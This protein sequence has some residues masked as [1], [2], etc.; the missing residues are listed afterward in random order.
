[1]EK[2]PVR[3]AGVLGSLSDIN[4]IRVKENVKSHFAFTLSPVSCD[5]FVQAVEVESTKI[6]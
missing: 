6:G 2:D 5:H 3:I 1:M 4:L